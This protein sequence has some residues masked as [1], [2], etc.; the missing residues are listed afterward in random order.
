M[1]IFIGRKLLVGEDCEDYLSF[2][3]IKCIYSLKIGLF[4]FLKFLNY[5]VED[6]Q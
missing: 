1:L 5:L 2:K 6:V 3:I 4:I